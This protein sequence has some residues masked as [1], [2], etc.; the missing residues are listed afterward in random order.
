MLLALKGYVGYFAPEARF[1]NIIPGS[2]KGYEKRKSF[3][4]HMR[5]RQCSLFDS[6]TLR[7][8]SHKNLASDLKVIKC[9]QDLSCD[10]TY[11]ST[12]QGFE[13]QC[14]IIDVHSKKALGSFQ[15]PKMKAELVE[16]AIKVVVARYD[17]PE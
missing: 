5:H 3:S 14:D 17:L 7:D 4:K 16:N 13:Y 12:G 11:I 6:R 2:I 8:C 9:Y 10:T 15:G 1:N